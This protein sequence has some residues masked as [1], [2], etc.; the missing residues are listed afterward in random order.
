MHPVKRAVTLVGL[1]FLLLC[2]AGCASLSTTAAWSGQ[3]VSEPEHPKDTTWG[4]VA[5]QVFVVVLQ[6]ICWGLAQAAAS[7][8][9]THCRH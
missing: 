6:G 7:G 3:E 1:L 8:A 4:D 5:V 9:F 2:G